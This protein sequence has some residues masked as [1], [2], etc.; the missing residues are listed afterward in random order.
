MISDNMESSTFFYDCLLK[1]ICDYDSGDTPF[2]INLICPNGNLANLQI[3]KDTIIRTYTVFMRIT[4]NGSIHILRET[5]MD[6]VHGIS[7]T[8]EKGFFNFPEL[9]A[10]L[11]HVGKYHG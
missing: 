11:V 4:D 9:V 7:E 10:Y 8:T 6:T 2:A 1:S 3:V 5:S